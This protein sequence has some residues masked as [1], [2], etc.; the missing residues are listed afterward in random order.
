STPVHPHFCWRPQRRRLHGSRNPGTSG[1]PDHILCCAG[2]PDHHHP[3]ASEASQPEVRAALATAA[4][5]TGARYLDVAI[6]ALDKIA[7]GIHPTWAA[8]Q[9]LADQ[10]CDLY[11]NPP[12]TLVDMT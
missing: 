1:V 10:A 12:P 7:D 11:I 9:Q 2:R 4:L 3:P 8:H 6:D 5:N